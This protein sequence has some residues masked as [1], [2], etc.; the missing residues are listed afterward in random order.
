MVD[1]TVFSSEQDGEDA[2]PEPSGS[3]KAGTLGRLQRQMS[4]FVRRLRFDTEDPSAADWLRDHAEGE[5]PL[6]ETERS[7]LLNLLKFGSVRVDDVMVPR[8]N[9]IAV[10]IS[11]SF[12]DLVDLFRDANH[13]RLPVYQQTLDNPLGM[14]HIKDILAC[15]ASPEE[16]DE[17][18]ASALRA[19][20]KTNWCRLKRDVLFVPP[21][22]PAADL[23]VMMQKKRI[24]MALVIDEYGGTEG[25]VTIEDLVE[26]IVGDI[27]DEHDKDIVHEFVVLESGGYQ[28]D[29]GIEIEEFERKTNFDLSLEKDDFE[30]IDT[31]GGLVFTLAGRVPSRGEIIR[32]PGGY[33]LEIIEAD[34]R[35]IHRL[36]VV[37]RPDRPQERDEGEEI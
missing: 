32:H 30:E 27:E 18:G 4:R 37:P 5:R 3:T 25:L 9:I 29:A 15:F 8:A 21:S 13:S 34:P 16:E 14:I 12:N 22:M 26:T 11:I 20:P 31:L 6:D 17:D 24:H 19:D 10:E 33:D 35:R 28:V 1:A 23:L 2:S 36:R 7:M